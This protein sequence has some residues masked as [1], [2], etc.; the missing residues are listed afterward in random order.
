MILGEVL[1][2]MFVSVGGAV[3]LSVCLS[4]CLL[5]HNIPRGNSSERFLVSWTEGM[6]Q[7]FAF[8]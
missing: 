7:D 3:W 5:K 2:E 8:F 1:S 6:P 4:V